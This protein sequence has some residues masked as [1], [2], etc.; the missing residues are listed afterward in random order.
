VNILENFKNINTFLFDVDGV[1]T[2]SKVL[3]TEDGHFLRSVSIRDGF[4]IS[5]AIK[6]GYHIAVISGGHSNGVIARLRAL[7]IEHVYTRIRTKTDV[8]A[9]H[10]SEFS[11]DLTRAIYMGDDVPD[12][13]VMKMVG[14]PCC[15]S[16]AIP[17]IISISKYVSP[18]IGGNGCVRD[19]I[20]KVL[21]L[22]GQ[23]PEE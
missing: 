18:H 11:L 2:N 20:E 12:I 13:G 4:A 8:L 22:N 17:Q 14:L 23:W 15:P 5:E 21:R 10:A 9:D 19:V 7:G 16:D 6:L 1:M 3:L